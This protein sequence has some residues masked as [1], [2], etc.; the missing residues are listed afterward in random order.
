MKNQIKTLHFSH[1][2]MSILDMGRKTFLLRSLVCDQ[3]LKPDLTII[4]SNLIMKPQ[5]TLKFIDF[6]RT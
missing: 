5:N 3:L 2:S 4:L 1:F 6:A